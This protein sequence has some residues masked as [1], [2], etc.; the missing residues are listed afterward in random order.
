MLAV[1]ITH[2]A[3]AACHTNE[4]AEGVD[5]VDILAVINPR[6]RLYH[7]IGEARVIEVR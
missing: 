7:L 6:R 2:H 4:R 3:V 1:K 5:G